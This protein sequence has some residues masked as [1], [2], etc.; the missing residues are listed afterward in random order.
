MSRLF[1]PATNGCEVCRAPWLS[2]ACRVEGCK[3]WYGAQRSGLLLPDWRPSV[4]E[5]A[6]QPSADKKALERIEFSLQDF[7]R[8]DRNVR[9][10]FSFSLRLSSAAEGASTPLRAKAARKWGPRGCGPQF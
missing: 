6:V 10:G 4:E 5:L 9:K 2:P 3:R 1:R 8:K 7:Y